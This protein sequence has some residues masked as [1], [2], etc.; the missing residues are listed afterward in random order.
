M[1][2]ITTAKITYRD[3][4]PYGWIALKFCRVEFYGYRAKELERKWDGIKNVRYTNYNA[5][6]KKNKSTI[7]NLKDE[8][9]AIYD[10][11]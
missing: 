4:V 9:A 2:K 5:L 10:S 8:A 6:V 7:A 11:I 3:Y 1:S